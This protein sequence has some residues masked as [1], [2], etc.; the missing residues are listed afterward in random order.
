VGLS[1][2]QS[3]IAIAQTAVLGDSHGSEG[4]PL[5][6]SNGGVGSELGDSYV[7]GKRSKA[8]ASQQDDGDQDNG[9]KDG[10]VLQV[11]LLAQIYGINLKGLRG[12]HE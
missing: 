5:P 8:Y 3:G 10:G 2:W 12:L 1:I 6:P 11:G 4:L 9:I 7:G